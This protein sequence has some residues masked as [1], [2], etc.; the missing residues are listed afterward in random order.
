MKNKRVITKQR[1]KKTDPQQEKV[2]TEAINKTLIALRKNFIKQ[3][4]DNKRLKHKLNHFNKM[5]KKLSND[6]KETFIS[7]Y[8]RLDD[9]GFTD[10][11]E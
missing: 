8:F 7:Y 3:T 1:I 5:F 2:K 11:E 10:G 9:W 4:A 6:E